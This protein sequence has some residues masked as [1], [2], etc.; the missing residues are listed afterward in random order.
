MWGLVRK[1]TRVVA[2]RLVGKIYCVGA[3]LGIGY[4][5]I[6]SITVWPLVASGAGGAPPSISLLALWTGG[7]ATSVSSDGDV[8]TCAGV[9]PCAWGWGGYRIWQVLFSRKLWLLLVEDAG[10][11]AGAYDTS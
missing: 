7:C 11:C 5:C 4:V 6:L 1:P 10:S 9:C 8:H 2:R 3:Q